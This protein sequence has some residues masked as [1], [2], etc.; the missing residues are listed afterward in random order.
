MGSTSTAVTS[1]SSSASSR[2]W[3]SGHWKRLHRCDVVYFASERCIVA[4][5]EFA[6]SVPRVP[7]LVGR[8]TAGFG[9][10][11]WG[12]ALFGARGACVHASTGP[13]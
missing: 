2:T 8:R 4:V 12:D 11:S 5:S 3:P 9:G 7:Q 6:P 1:E 13:V 10:V